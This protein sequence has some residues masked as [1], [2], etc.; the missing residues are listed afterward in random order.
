MPKSSAKPR[1]SPQPESTH[2][3]APGTPRAGKEVD[4]ADNQSTPS[5]LARTVSDYQR[6]F[7]QFAAP[8]NS[9]VAGPNYFTWD[10]AY[11]QKALRDADTWF[12]PGGTSRNKQ[13]L[14]K[15]LDLSCFEAPDR[16]WVSDTVSKLV[17]RIDGSTPGVTDRT[18]ESST[19]PM[20]ARAKLQEHPMKYIFFHQDVRPPYIG[21]LSSIRT[22]SDALRL[23]RR[24]CKK[25]REEVDYEYDSEAEWDEPEEGE[26]L[27]SEGEDDDDS[28]AD[29]EELEEFL[30]DEGADGV[31][32]PRKHMLSGDMLPVS[33]GLCWENDAQKLVTSVQGLAINPSDYRMEVLSGELHTFSVLIGVLICADT[34]D[35]PIDPFSSAY[36]PDESHQPNT[37]LAA[38]VDP[39]RL[40]LLPRANI[41][42]NGATPQATA[43]T[44]KPVKPPKAPKQVRLLAGQELEEFKQVVQGSDLT[45]QGLLAVVK[46]KLPKVPNAVLS[47]TLSTVAARV[48]AK[49]A[50]KRW[51]II[52]GQ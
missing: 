27:G 49:E 30:D 28:I 2:V 7:L 10:Q 50:D 44:P 8:S 19:K 4:G 5:K 40:P 13:T 38:P 52:P 9:V 24:P 26:D 12:A 41:P 42:T 45:K 31:S 34:M 16:G 1:R 32:K 17:T 43:D 11:T 33:T 18:S 48:G 46:K 21:T 37:H 22:R 36:W 23:A 25:S 20:D 15:C 35:F 6:T 51:V 29:G 14:A 3:S 39:T 47:D